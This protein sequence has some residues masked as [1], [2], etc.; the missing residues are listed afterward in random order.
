MKTTKQI[1][2]FFTA[3]ITVLLCSLP[4]YAQR[5]SGLETPE[6][7]TSNSTDPIGTATGWTLFFAEYGFSLLGLVLILGSVSVFWQVIKMVREGRAD[8]SD[9]TGK[10][11]FS[12]IILVVGFAVLAYGYQN[13][14]SIRGGATT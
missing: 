5:L 3:I 8:Y 6:G 13:I 11:I 14:D 4:A 1:H 12:I 2:R 10:I 7:V 9:L